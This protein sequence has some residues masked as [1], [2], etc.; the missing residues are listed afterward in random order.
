[1]VTLFLLGARG[2]LENVENGHQL[3]CFPLEACESSDTFYFIGISN[4]F[5]YFSKIIV[6]EEKTAERQAAGRVWRRYWR[7][8]WRHRESHH[9][10]TAIT[11]VLVNPRRERARY[12]CKIVSPLSVNN[13][14]KS[15]M[16]GIIDSVGFF[17]GR[18]A[19]FWAKT[20]FDLWLRCQRSNKC[21]S[22]NTVANSSRP[23]L[24]T[25]IASQ[26]FGNEVLALR[27]FR[28]IA[29]F[30]MRLTNTSS[31]MDGFD[32]IRKI[33]GKRHGTAW[34]FICTP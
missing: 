6:W 25:L 28:N 12:F 29:L 21:T 3:S 10:A 26:H 2:D 15:H 34:P 1:M 23:Y 30:I 17:V 8:R 13:G 5:S 9:P 4:Y 16:Q 32:S 7:W 31:P 18:F 19:R 14:L 22:A 11:W 20:A 33:H 24:R 27:G